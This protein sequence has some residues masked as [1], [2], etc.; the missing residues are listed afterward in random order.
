MARWRSR[1]FW[2][3]SGPETVLVSGLFSVKSFLFQNRFLYRNYIK[4]GTEIKVKNGAHAEF[5]MPYKMGLF[6]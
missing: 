5:Y 6:F 3:I 4:N 2:W 1:L